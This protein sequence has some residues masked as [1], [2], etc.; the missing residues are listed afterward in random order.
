MDYLSIAIF[1]MWVGR[2]DL[3]HRHAF[4]Q[5]ALR[6]RLASPLTTELLSYAMALDN[7]V[8]GTLQ[9]PLVVARGVH[10]HELAWHAMSVKTLPICQGVFLAAS[11]ISLML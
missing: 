2:L 7:P 4:L 10:V 6:T 9:P 1:T 11:A 3:L 5:L 8:G